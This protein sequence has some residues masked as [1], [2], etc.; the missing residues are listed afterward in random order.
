MYEFFEG[1][2]AWALKATVENCPYDDNQMR[3]EWVAG[4]LSAQRDYGSKQ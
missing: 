2:A 3:S 1:R 4:W